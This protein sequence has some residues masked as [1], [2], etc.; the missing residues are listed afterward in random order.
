M[1]DFN[2]H[3]CASSYIS[4][5]NDFIDILVCDCNDSL[6]NIPTGVTRDSQ[7][8]LDQIYVESSFLYKSGVPKSDILDHYATFCSLF[9]KTFSYSEL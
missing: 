3:L 2:V 5:V 4:Y 1:G 6:I 8:F 9:S 7:T